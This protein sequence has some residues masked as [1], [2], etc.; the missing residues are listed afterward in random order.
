[1]GTDPL[2]IP[3]P[4]PPPLPW[5][6]EG[7][8]ISYCL[9]EKKRRGGK[10]RR[11]RV[12]TEV[13]FLSIRLSSSPPFLFRRPTGQEIGWLVG[14]ICRAVASKDDG[15]CLLAFLLWRE[16]SLFERVPVK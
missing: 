2:L 7:S 8:L 15:S 16:K 12:V 13:V 6:D 11:R 10:E 4:P 5:T 14:G 3:P 1:M 9:P